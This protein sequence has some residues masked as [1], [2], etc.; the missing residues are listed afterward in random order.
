M[1]SDL[2]LE[3]PHSGGYENIVT[4][5]ELF[6]RFLFAY[7][8]STPDAKT[9]G[10]VTNF[11]MTK[12]SYS[13]TT[14][15]SYK[16]SAF[17]SH[18]IKEVGGALGITLKHATTKH[19]QTS[20]LLERSHV[21]IRQALKI[22]TGGRRSL[23]HRYVTIAVPNY[24]T[25]Y[26]ASI[27]CEPSR[28]FHGRIHYKVLDIK[29]GFRPL[30]SAPPNSQNAQDVFEQ[31]EK[32]FQDVRKDAKQAYV[33]YIAYYDKKA[34][35]SKLKQTDYVYVLQ[36]AADPRGSKFPRRVFRW[37]GPYT[38]GKCYRTTNI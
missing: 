17:V 29:T 1:Q 28:V 23:W 9:I 11:I 7:P 5:T 12:H 8:T 34:N 21:S 14:L 26:H 24:N 3:L 38:I 10:K 2:V 36:P 4:A 13:P 27:G 6:S 19:A 33:K 31:T 25:S 32:I 16:G 15:V 35:T 30:T 37:I 18:L 20:E 22:E